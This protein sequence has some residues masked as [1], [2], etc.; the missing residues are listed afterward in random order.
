MVTF[1]KVGPVTFAAN[2][3]LTKQLPCLSKQLFAQ[4]HHLGATAFNIMAL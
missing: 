2:Q 4:D 3:K 1:K